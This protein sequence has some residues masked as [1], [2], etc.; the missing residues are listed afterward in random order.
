[1]KLRIG[2]LM[3]GKSLEKEVSFNS[4]R[5]ICDYLDTTQYS[6][7]PL[8]QS[9]SKIY[10][11][12]WHFLHRGKTSDFEHRLASEGILIAWDNLK[13]QVDF[14]YIAQHGRY[15]E[16]GCLQ[17]FLEVLGIP[18]N[19]SG[20]FA[21]ALRSDKI[22]LK[23]FLNNANILTP[24]FITVEPYEID[25]FETYKK[26][27]I[28]RLERH[29][30]TT[31][32]VVKPYNEGS[33]LGISIANKNTLE[34]ALKKACYIEPYHKKRVLIEEKIIGMEFTCI[35]LTDYKTGQFFALPPTESISHVEIGFFDYEQKYMPGRGIKRTPA[36]CNAEITARIQKTC[37]AVMNA[38]EL[39]PMGRIDGF[40][41]PEGDIIIIDP[42]TFSGM[43][44]SSYIFN[45]AAEINMTP[46]QL[47]NHIIETE[48]HQYNMLSNSTD[49][50]KEES[51]MIQTPKIR[52][53]I[54]LAGA[55]NEKETSLDSGRN[56]FY[57]LS[58]HKYESIAIFVDDNLE[59]YTL[60]QSQLVRNSTTE[61]I[62]LLTSEQKIQWNDLPSIADFV[63][64]ALHGGQ[65]EN[66]SVQGILEILGLPYNGSSVLSSALCINKYKTNQ[67]LALH[68]FDVPRNILIS[69]KEFATPFDT[70]C[71]ANAPQN[72]QGERNKNNLSS[73]A[74]SQCHDN[75]DQNKN[76]LSFSAHS[77][78]HDNDDRNKNNLSFSAHP[79]CHDN[80]D[81]N[82]NSLSFSAHPQCHDND[83]RNKNN[84]SFSAHPQCHDN[85][86]RNKN[87]LSFSA[88]P[89]CHDN[90][91]RNKNNL[92]SSA[93]SQCHDNDDRNKNSLSF[94]AHPECHNNDDRNKNSLSFSAHPE[95]HNNDDRNKNSLSFSAHPEC[96]DS[97]VS[98]GY[99]QIQ[100]ITNQLPF[101]L[102]VKPD[103]DGC[104]MMV[105]KATN[106]QE[107]MSAID[108]I[109][110]E[111]D[112]VLIE[113]YING[114][115]LTV[116]VIG[117]EHPQVLP[118]SKAVSMNGILSIQEKFLP[119][120]GENQTPAPLPHK[121]LEFIQQTIEKVFI[122]LQC[123]GYARI[124]CFYQNAEESPTGTERVII[125]EVNTLPGLTPATCLFHQA[126]EIGLKPI[127]FIDTL[128]T[129]G[130]EEHSLK[131]TPTITT[132]LYKEL[133]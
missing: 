99:K 56:V 58:P 86:D 93:H 74:H 34:K 38:L 76:S 60:T 40:V 36:R 47:I 62:E 61:I 97:G 31:D 21:S 75:D 110:Q 102:I 66:G 1:M 45:Q 48:L 59:L 130:L 22:L 46:S 19:G 122:T 123:K 63:F 120:A 104:S 51:L 37:I 84:L 131:N 82:K 126:A 57:K 55:S 24:R 29:H 23:T 20:I 108:K 132:K 35:V 83:D 77:Q 114:V 101:P 121:T 127:D 117:N 32:Y 54:L 81:R 111:K 87:N 116:G 88:H 129:L 124:D 112:N 133:L 69:K 33:S 52:V 85:D 18:Y 100:K 9:N 68:G 105:Q 89:Q 13:Q 79:Q 41:T 94:S 27:I 28:E 128:I 103:N 64:I 6:I 44:P 106:T 17:G 50:N 107:L 49:N 90:D 118:P 113:E 30:I 71:S 16:D 67:L 5:T 98:K 109:L 14:M 73:S 3:G 78:C 4:G 25:N 8:F 96:H 72:T 39:S 53:A 65:G 11:L 115:E 125:L 43:A 15:A 95:C 91:D 26:N 80:D 119:G 92:S 2:I 12:P 10:I 7:V 70:F 42:N